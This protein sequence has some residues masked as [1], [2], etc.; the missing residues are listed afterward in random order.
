M[1]APTAKDH[2]VPHISRIPANEGDEVNLFVREYDGTQGH[3]PRSPVLMLH[4]RS[5]PVVA[6]YDLTGP[7]S[8]ITYSWAQQLAA[9]H[10]DVFLMDLQGNGRSPRPK[11]DEPRNANPAQ[12]GVLTPNPL[13]VPYT[14]PP[15]YPHELGNSESEWAE[16]ATVVAFIKALPRMTTPI[17]FIGWS[18]A[19]PV[20]GPYT[21]QHPEHV[22]S[23]FLLAPVYPPLGRWSEDAA[24]PFGRPAEAAVLPVSQ[25]PVT[26]GF[27]M[28]V[29]DKR[30]FK[31][32]W[33]REQ[34][35]VFQRDPDM[36]DRAWAAMM[37]NDPVGSSWGSPLPDGGAEGIH[38]YRNSY[39]W[40]WNNETAPYQNPTGTHVLGDRVPLV[41]VHGELDRTVNTPAGS[42]VPP[43]VRFSV[44]ALYS[45]V[46]G[47][48]K[49][50]FQLEGAG[51]SVVWERAAEVV[52]EISRHWLQNKYR[53]WGHTGGSFYRA[54]DGTLT[55]L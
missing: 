18:A 35:S 52:H 29:S 32:A 22:K 13:P 49:L 15:L 19:G 10:Y 2:L 20:M 21:L 45:A 39:W 17:D 12:R 5:V 53:V 9:L 16:L 1:P 30:G 14:G 40:G 38:R 4:G 46:K 42:P 3:Q 31:F 23:L 8:D 24:N 11:M 27:P 34:G 41:I 33:D 37:A 44:P 26:F 43:T 55:P 51:H 48:K 7:G 50:M 36:V 6:G 47:P 25:P 54:A 28:H